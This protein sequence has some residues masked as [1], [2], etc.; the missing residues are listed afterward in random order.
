MG[1]LLGGERASTPQSGVEAPRL[2]KRSL[3][4]LYCIVVVVVVPD[5]YENVC[6]CTTS[7]P[8]YST[9]QIERSC[10]PGDAGLH[11]APRGLPNP[12]PDANRI[13]P[14]SS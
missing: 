7:L 8:C 9:S 6:L 10:K 4:R 1:R 11:E 12:S 13:L 2:L 14:P 5:T 3:S